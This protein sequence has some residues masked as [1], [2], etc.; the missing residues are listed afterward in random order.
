MPAYATVRLPP[1]LKHCCVLW[2][3]KKLP[4]AGYSVVKDHP[5][6]SRP[7]DPLT[8]SLASRFVAPLRS[9]GARLPAR[10]IPLAHSRA[11]GRPM[12]L[13]LFS[14]HHRQTLTAFAALVHNLRSALAGLP[15]VAASAASDQ[16]RLVENTGLEP[17]TSW[18][19]TRRSPS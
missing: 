15:T 11:A 19:Q 10:S 16:R 6:D 14:V 18:L 4:F 7:S 17:V 9:R 1:S 5:R 2:I 3:R 8:R 13:K 12:D